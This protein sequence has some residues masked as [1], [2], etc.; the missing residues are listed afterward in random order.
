MYIYIPSD[1]YAYIYKPSAPCGPA[2]P[3][4][5]CCTYTGYMYCTYTGYMYCTYTG[6]MR[7]TYTGYM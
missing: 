7:C 4:Y 6:Y 5:M 3:G 2:P 1:M